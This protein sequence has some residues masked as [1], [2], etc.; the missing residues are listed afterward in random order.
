VVYNGR[1][2]D[3]LIGTEVAGYR[4]E[5]EVGRGG[6]GVVYLAEHIRLGRKVALKI[7]PPALAGDD[8]F[9]ER[10]ERE[11]RMAAALD[12]PNIIPVFD[13]D[14]AEGLLFISM[15]YVPGTDLK[16]LLE[17]EG[18][19]EPVRAVRF[20]EQVAGALD[21]AHARGLVH[22]DVKP[23]NILVARDGGTEHCYLTDFGL[24]KLTTTRAGLTGS[25]QFVGTLDY[26]APEQVR[27]EGSDGR[28]DVYSLGC[29][30]YECLAGSR[31]FTR[32]SDVAMIYAHLTD[33]PPRVSQARPDAAAFD[34]IVLRALAKEPGA[35]FPT[36]GEL[37]AAARAA[38]SRRVAPPPPPPA[39]GPVAA[40]PVATVAAPAPGWVPPRRRVWPWLVGGAVAAALLAT[41]L[42][43]ALGRSRPDTPAPASLIREGTEVVAIQEGDLDGDGLDEAVIASEDAEEPELGLPT[44][45]LEVFA[46][47]DGA[48]RRILDGRED[49]PPGAGAPGEILARDPTGVTQEVSV[50]E[51]VDLAGD[52]R[53]EIVTA[54]FNSGAT[55]GPTELW[56]ISLEEGDSFRTQYYDR[57][58]RGGTV[59]LEGS[60]IM[61]E[62]GVYENDDPSCCPSDTEFQTIG[63]DSQEGRVRVIESFTIPND[64]DG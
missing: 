51:I 43:L 49:A 52:G 55:A 7:L 15:R 2:S 32:E 10:F 54:V 3:P 6:M 11:S 38:T 37:A 58:A 20:V 50:V 39:P 42:V 8:T 30:V 22:R 45:Y 29:I 36:A 19:L 64:P 48:W 25:G 1:V 16:A 53:P 47:R 21:A 31:P 18:R 13:A 5:H 35:R 62:F 12:H 4:I 17:Y 34:P 44:P 40:A 24:G 46:Y 60:R 27:G 28:A 23:G 63:Y 14:E 9:R 26:V 59:S 57:T 41:A 33:P 56:V 61:F